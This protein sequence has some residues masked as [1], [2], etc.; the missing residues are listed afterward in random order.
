MNGGVDLPRTQLKQEA[1]PDVSPRAGMGQAEQFLDQ[2]GIPF[3][4][5]GTGEIE[6]LPNREIAR[7]RCHK[8]EETVFHFGVPESSELVDFVF[9]KPSNRSGCHP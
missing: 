5:L 7:M 3:A 9:S 4:A 1:S 2:S 6:E 8:V